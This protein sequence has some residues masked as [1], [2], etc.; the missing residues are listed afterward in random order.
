MVHPWVMHGYQ[1]PFC[2]T[3]PKPA[4]GD[5]AWRRG[6]MKLRGSYFSMPVAPLYFFGFDWVLARAR[7][8]APTK[9]LESP[10]ASDPIYPIYPRRRV[11][12]WRPRI[13]SSTFGAPL[14]TTRWI[15]P[16][17]SGSEAFL[18]IRGCQA[19]SGLFSPL[20]L[21]ELLEGKVRKTMKNLSGSKTTSKPMFSCYQP[22]HWGSHEHGLRICKK[23][24]S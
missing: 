15:S 24:S 6:F 8:V 19:V 1:G 4:G 12:S 22:I 23:D 7:A 5:A 20:N 11:T 10:Q 17:R 2:D 13:T 21:P 16:M 3:S 18:T 9:R 14:T